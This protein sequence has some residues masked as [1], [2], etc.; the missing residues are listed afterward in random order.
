MVKNTRFA[1]KKLCKGMECGNSEF[2][3]IPVNFVI[4]E[5]KRKC[6]KFFA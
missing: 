5:N 6:I 4:A 1:D 2:F 3:V